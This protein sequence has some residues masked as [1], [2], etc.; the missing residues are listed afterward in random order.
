MHF[1]NVPFPLLVN[2]ILCTSEQ[3]NRNFLFYFHS[4]TAALFLPHESLL[5]LHYF[6]FPI[7][8]PSLPAHVPL[9]FKPTLYLR[10][11]LKPN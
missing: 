8:P 5:L 1:F 7:S 9:S 2:I 10:T 4:C 3:A 6:L 11:M